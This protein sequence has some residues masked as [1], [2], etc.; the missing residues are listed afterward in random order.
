MLQP[1]E[2]AIVMAAK[3]KPKQATLSRR[4]HRGH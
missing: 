2:A 1:S 3:N 4:A